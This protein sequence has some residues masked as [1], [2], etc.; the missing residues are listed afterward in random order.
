[1]TSEVHQYENKEDKMENKFSKLESKVIKDANTLNH[2]LKDENALKGKEERFEKMMRNSK[3]LP[4]YPDDIHHHEMHH[5]FS[6]HAHG[7]ISNVNHK[8]L[9]HLNFTKP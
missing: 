7:H 6:P 3:R 4:P 2:V 9:F 5:P 1:M 8:S